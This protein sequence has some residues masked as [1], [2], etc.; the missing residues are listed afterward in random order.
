MHKW[1]SSKRQ[2]Q[3][4]WRRQQQRHMWQRM[5]LGWQCV[6]AAASVWLQLE[7]HM[8]VGMCLFLF[9]ARWAMVVV[10]MERRR[11]QLQVGP[12]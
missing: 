1:I 7:S 11:Q 9:H 4:W 8:L 2:V 3:L 6:A 5:R 12:P 10:V